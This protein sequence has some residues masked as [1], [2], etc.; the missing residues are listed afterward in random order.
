MARQWVGDNQR[1][2]Y[3]RTSVK[4]EFPVQKAPGATIAYREANRTE[5]ARRWPFRAV[6]GGWGL[7]DDLTI[8]PAAP[9]SIG[10]AGLQPDSLAYKETRRRYGGAGVMRSVMASC[11]K[12]VQLGSIREYAY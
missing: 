11:E 12:I 10:P 1:L 6:R 5:R 7:G 4:K 8:A 3:E 2:K 9:A